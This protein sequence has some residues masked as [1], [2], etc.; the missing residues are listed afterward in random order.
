MVFSDKSRESSGQPGPGPVFGVPLGQCVDV[1][2]AR[3]RSTCALL[4]G[5]ENIPGNN[6]L[7]DSDLLSPVT[8]ASRSDSRAS[9]GSVADPDLMRH[10]SQDKMMMAGSTESLF[11]IRRQ[12][13]GHFSA[14]DTLSVGK[15]CK[16]IL[17]K[18]IFLV[19][20]FT[21]QVGLNPKKVQFTGAERCIKG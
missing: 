8:K 11:D 21:Q 18:N 17:Q 5:N 10:R 19:S 3:K 9:F 20:V 2:S 16:N 12:S 14:L 15:R 7:T 4:T 1:P 13:L 6:Q